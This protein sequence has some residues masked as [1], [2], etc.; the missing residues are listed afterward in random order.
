MTIKILK[1]ILENTAYKTADIYSY[2]HLTGG[3]MNT[4]WRVD[5]S[6]GRI[7]VKV[8]D[9]DRN[10]TTANKAIDLWKN[11]V[12]VPEPIHQNEI[13]HDGK[14][15]IVYRYIGG[16]EI[17]H[18]DHYQLEQITNVI[19]A[20]T[21]KV[22][23]IAEDD[24]VKVKVVDQQ[25]Q[26]LK[27]LSETKIDQTVVQNV[28]RGFESIR[29]YMFENSLYIG[30][31]DL[32][33]GNVIWSLN[34]LFG[35]IDFDE[36]SICTEEYE[37]VVFATKHCMREEQFDTCYLYEILKQYY[38]ELTDDILNKYKLTFMFYTLKVLMEKIY[39][40]Q[41]DILDLYDERQMRD[42]WNWWY[43]LY[44]NIDS[45][46]KEIKEIGE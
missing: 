17:T 10:L 33:H 3:L 20:T 32:N 43:Q 4:I 28:L 8:Y 19:R 40:Y 22:D 7:I 6:L 26:A 42:N 35:V 27:Q 9:L 1:K 34:Q 5:T 44:Q 39:F 31:H 45:I 41:Y 13:R 21:L 24:V 29:D 16:E 25:Y 12:S 23:E 38:G 14:R 11:F 18:P 36:A 2:K 15:I 46:M 37:L 30:H